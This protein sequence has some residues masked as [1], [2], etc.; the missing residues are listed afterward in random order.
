M[1][2]ALQRQHPKRKSATAP[3]YALEI[4]RE[5]DPSVNTGEHVPGSVY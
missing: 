3:G 2:S 5:I 4:L 1:R